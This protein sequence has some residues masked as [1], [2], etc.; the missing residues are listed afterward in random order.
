[1]EFPRVN[2]PALRDRLNTEMTRISRQAILAA[3]QIVMRIPRFTGAIRL[4]VRPVEDGW[5]VA[6]SGSSLPIR[7][8]AKKTEAVKEAKK[9]AARHEGTVSVRTRKPSRP[10]SRQ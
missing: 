1:M 9:L 8:Y 5:M 3:G 4:E 7:L 10:R 2:V 6:E